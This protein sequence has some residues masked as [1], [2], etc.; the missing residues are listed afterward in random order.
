[1]GNSYLTSAQKD[2]LGNMFY[3]QHATFMRPI[4]IYQTAKETVIV[5]NEQHNYLFQDAPMNSLTSEVI[6]SGVFGARI[7]YGKKEDLASFNAAHRQGGGDQNMIRLEEGEVRI[8]LD[9][10]GS[11]FLNNVERIQFDGMTFQI[12]TSQR[13][14]GLFDPKFNTFYLKKLN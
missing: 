3:D 7:L 10:T 2:I 11:A 4:T 14:H 12:Q 6:Q 8:K 5:S 13:P 1:M 9:P